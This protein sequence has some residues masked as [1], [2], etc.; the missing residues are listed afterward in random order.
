MTLRFV[1]IA[2]LWL[3]S[4]AA[5]S[6][7]PDSQSLCAL[8]QALDRIIVAQTGYP[9]LT[10]CP[11]IGFGLL[12]EQSG[13]RSQAGAYLPETGQIELAPD[14]DLATAS[15]RSFLLHELVHAAQYRGGAPQRLACPAMLEAEAY[16]LQADYLIANGAAR[17]AMLMRVL[18]DHLGSCRQTAE[19]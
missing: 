11:D 15:G 8:A 12:P 9:G 19:Y 17:E 2:T 5:A 7:G 3:G 13:Q 10:G 4:P 1:L 18:A 16:R 14:L 6:A